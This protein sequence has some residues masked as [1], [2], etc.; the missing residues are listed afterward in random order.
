MSQPLK[1]A[2][3]RLE[4]GEPEEGLPAKIAARLGL[5]SDA[6]AQWRILRKSLDARNHDDLH[7]TY[8]T[9]VELAEGGP[10]IEP[11]TPDIQPFVPER[12]DW[13]EPGTRPLRHR[14]VIVGSGPAGLIA[15]YLLAQHGYRPLILERGRAVKDRVADVRRFDE[16]GPL[17]PES[18]YLFGEGGA[19]TFSDG[20]LTSRAGGPDVRRVLE[21][22]AECHGKA[23]IVYEH[24]P[25]LGSNR[26]PLVVRTLRRKLEELGGEV[27]FSCLVEDL[28]LDSGRLRGLSTTSGYIA[29]DLAILAIGHSARDTYSMLLRR[30]VPM[31]AKPFQL[32]VRIEQPQ[33]GIDRARY[34]HHA[35]HP[36]LGAADYSASVR[37]GR[38]DLFTFCMCAGG[39]VMPSV[40]DPG[41]FCTNGMSESRHDSPFANSGL[42][43][44]IE[45]AETGSIHPLAGVHY[46]QRVERLSYLAAGRTYA[47]PLQWARDFLAG[48]P[49]RGPIPTSY[50]RGGRTIDLRLFLPDPVVVALERGLPMMDRRFAGHFLRDATLTGPESR[51]SSPV[52]ILRDDATRESPGVAGLY[53]CGEGAGYAG[54]IISAA[55]DGLR[56]ARVIVAT[57]A[58]AF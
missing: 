47:A 40:S 19:G 8:A 32:G 37:T 26:L 43:V 34:G 23:S 28:D 11:G 42:V 55:V 17:D 58:N 45:P 46:Q 20:K 4:L 13:P 22:L 6:I 12:F 49:S 10:R 24:R 15:G 9:A 2:N 38:R 30:S 5:G 51:G 35:G 53:P 1:V 52:R 48:R 3:I 33:A 57:Y 36:V 56:T 14:P 25:H 18:N 44:T 50:R 29:A 39:Y 41:Y 16:G 27:R 21:I 7:F 54:G 31:A